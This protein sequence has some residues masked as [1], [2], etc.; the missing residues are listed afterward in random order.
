MSVRVTLICNGC[1]EEVSGPTFTAA[2]NS[3][4]DRGWI[5]KE[6]KKSGH[7]HFC[8]KCSKKPIPSVGGTTRTSESNRI[9]RLSV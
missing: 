3:A 5:V 1:G 4:K 8:K 7:I 2:W 9:L 6:R